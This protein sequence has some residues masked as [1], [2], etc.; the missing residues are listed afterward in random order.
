MYVLKIVFLLSTFN[1]LVF[2]TTDLYSKS[3]GETLVKK[4]NFSE[5]GTDIVKVYFKYIIC[6][7]LHLITV[8]GIS[9]LKV[10][11]D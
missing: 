1:F 2:Q 7:I 3:D 9:S 8:S 6:Q 10:I 11:F 4:Y 5:S